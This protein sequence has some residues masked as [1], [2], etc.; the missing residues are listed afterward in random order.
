MDDTNNNQL[1]MRIGA[2]E[3]SISQL[4]SDMSSAFA[5]IRQVEQTETTNMALIQKDL[6][7][8]TT[9]VSLM[10][11]S[12]DTLAKTSAHHDTKFDEIMEKLDKLQEGQ[13]GYK[14][15][16]ARVLGW[17]AGVLFVMAGLWKVVELGIE[18]AKH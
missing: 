1:L 4:Q 10:A 14:I 18:F 2:H 6:A 17:I 16:K 7:K 13:T 9:D 5:Q 3:A 15:D 11:Q 8:I 12:I